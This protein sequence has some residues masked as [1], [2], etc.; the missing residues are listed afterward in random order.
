ML[1]ICRLGDFKK[2]QIV[3]DNEERA[4]VTDVTDESDNTDDEE[5]VA[6]EEVVLKEDM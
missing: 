6:K 1:N 4:E 5:V 2:H 3:H